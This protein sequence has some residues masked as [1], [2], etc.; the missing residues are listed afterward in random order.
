MKPTPPPPRFDQSSY[1]SMPSIREQQEMAR[2]KNR[3]MGLWSIG[4]IALVA[5]TV[6][7]NPP[8]GR[9]HSFTEASDF[10]ASKDSGCTNSGEGCHGEETSYDDFNVYH[11][12]TDCS[13]CHDKTGVGCLP[14]HSPK[15][16]ECQSCHDGTMPGAGDQVR[17]MDPYPK[18]HYRETTHTANSSDFKAVVRTVEDGK[19]GAACSDCHARD[20]YT[21]HQEVPQV[22]GS[23]Y[24]ESVGCGEC[25]NDTRAFG[26]EQ[27]TS[28]WKGRRCEDCHT[29]ESSSPVH[30]LA[31]AAAVET[32][33]GPGCGETGA[34]CHENTDVHS[35][36]AD[37]PKDCS[38]SA[39]KGEPGCHD[40]TLQAH[41]PAD[42][43]CGA[44]GEACHARY[45]NDE[46]SHEKDR[47]RHDARG[48]LAAGTLA[49][50]A[51]GTRTRCG[52]CHGSD[53]TAE[54]LRPNSAL[55]SA[56]VCDGCHNHSESTVI[57]VLRDWPSRGSAGQ[58]GDC[59]GTSDVPEAHLAL[60]DSHDGRTLAPDGSTDEFACT[61]SL[62]HQTTDVRT[63][64]TEAGCLAK[65]C[66][67]ATGDING[68]NTLSC[69]GT[70]AS[71][72]C[73]AGFSRF[74]GHGTGE[75]H[76]GT[77]LAADGTPSPGFCASV[78]CHTSVDLSRL[79]G[80]RCETAGCHVGEAKPASRSCGGPDPAT[81]CHAWFSAT[82]HFADHDADRTGTVNGVTYRVGENTGCFGCHDAD[83]I[84]SHTATADSPITGGGATS[85]RVC[86]DD[87]DDPGN[88]AYAGLR[89]VRKAVAGKD[90]RCV[91]C[92]RSGSAAPNMTSAASAHK[93]TSTKNPLPAGYVWADPFTEWRAAFESPMGGGHN[94][95]TA[96]VVGASSDKLFPQTSYTVGGTAYA[97]PLPANSGSTR[98]LKPQDGQDLASTEDIQHARLTC[99]DCHSSTDGMRGPHGAAVPVRIDPE[100]SQTEYANPSRGLSSQW[101]ATGTER[102]ICM[103]CHYL[104]RGSL[105]GTDEPGGHRVH[106]QHSQ[107]LSAPVWHP[108]RYGAKCIDCH[109]RIPHASRSPRLLTRTIAGPGRP[110]DAFPY[111][112]RD[113]EGLAGVRLQDYVDP[114]DMTRASCVTNGCHGYHDEHNHPEPSDVPTAP[115]WP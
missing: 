114:E 108:L 94:V 34:G 90:V 29:E 87:P 6:A 37:A 107:H 41:Q 65:G 38:G 100:Y 55:R 40:L 93:R 39:A 97:W 95:L 36:H 54:H 27:V 14:C 11:P 9:I 96:A 78:G 26:L 66:H 16:H 7:W 74:D 21:A 49:D 59:H 50:E 64:H 88:G 77:E 3:R 115:L 31:I 47:A 5:F 80:D 73:H 48:G 83:L 46:Y 51:T 106:S 61:G 1:R 17:L 33:G 92:H 63:L 56:N 82:Q 13:D 60:D 23:P 25:H 28:D 98:W 30:D 99:D 71:G 85:C 68:S 58:C 4:A 35:L 62:C 111:V 22:E 72:G 15:G 81:A 45:E 101:T 12:N 20:L 75:A 113:H 19:A 84:T 109:V 86:H 18:G 79:H 110:A 42:T 105:E 52:E 103:K 53:L 76:R 104:S 91:A 10:I 67:A 112:E 2:L 102:V 43:T 70:A 57:A 8:T 44:G 89:D 24:G 69:G 32:T